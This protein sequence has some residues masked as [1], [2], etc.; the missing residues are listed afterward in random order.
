MF[1]IGFDL[2]IF[3]ILEN[4]RGGYLWEVVDCILYM[5]EKGLRGE[6]FKKGVENYGR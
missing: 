6:I 3:G 4:W 1:I 2:W 5:M